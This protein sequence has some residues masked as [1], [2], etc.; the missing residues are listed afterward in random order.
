ME[1]VED[2][3][4]EMRRMKSKLPPRPS[5]EDLNYASH[6][7]DRVDN[8]MTAR[9]EEL[10][11]QTSPVGVPYHVFR[12][13]L[14]MREDLIRSKVCSMLSAHPLEAREIRFI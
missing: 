3:I 12:S 4:A 13:Y 7:I 11:K 1:S 2:V 6:T 8:N 14:Q 10:L 5:P 9:L